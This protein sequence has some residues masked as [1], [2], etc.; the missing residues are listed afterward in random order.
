MSDPEDDSDQEAP[1][2]ALKI[3]SSDNDDDDDDKM[4]IDESQPNS[5]GGGNRGIQSS[6]DDE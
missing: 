6:S 4:T 5:T 2:P 1:T 3:D